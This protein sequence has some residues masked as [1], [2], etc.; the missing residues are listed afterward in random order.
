MAPGISCLGR[1]P[2]GLVLTC[3][4]LATSPS[5]AV[6]V[7][8]RISAGAVY[9]DNLFLAPEGE[10]QGDF[11]GILEP[12]I[13]IS[14]AGTRYDFFL[15]YSLRSLFY[16][17]ESDS[18]GSFS[19]G[20]ATLRL[21]L[22][23]ERFFLSGLAD[24]RQTIIDPEAL[25]PPSNLPISG[26]IQDQVQVSVTP[27][28]RQPILGGDLRLAATVGRIALEEDDLQ[29]VDYLEANNSLTGPERDRGLTWALSHYY[30]A[31]DYDRITIKRQSVDLFLYA[32][33]GSGWAPFVSVGTESD[34]AEPTQ[35][36]LDY[37]TWSVGLRRSTEVSTA[38][39]SYGDRSFGSNF[40]VLLERRFGG[41]S[42]DYIRASYSETPQTPANIQ[43]VQAPA[44]PGP[45]PPADPG[46]SPGQ[47]PLLLPP[48]VGQAFLAR[49]GDVVLSKSFIQSTISLT[50]FVEDFESIPF[51]AFGLSDLG[52]DRSQYGVIG[53]YVYRFGQKLSFQGDL[54]VSDRTFEFTGSVPSSDTLLFA[55][56]GLDYQMGEKTSL[57]AWI[58]LNQQTNAEGASFEYDQKVAGF[59]I[60]RR[61]F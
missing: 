16:A 28:W 27:E 14:S 6:E 33:L 41:D 17:D 26:N 29:D 8:P 23:P 9:T 53:S 50:L 38:E 11:V 32:E 10:E 15:D 35:S 49:R 60:N 54:T 20:L 46:L 39:V 22:V 1:L 45:R 59:L 37:V 43:T 40:R 42:G 61:F 47:P 52:E 36:D 51:D 25:I 58:G 18:N 30:G 13:G 57:T 21:Q 48:G 7:V 12:G 34:F 55:R 19:N 4:C 31:Y 56:I 3:F 24:I 5:H 44:T 2:S